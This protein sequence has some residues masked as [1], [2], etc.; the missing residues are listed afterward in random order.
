MHHVRRMVPRVQT[1]VVGGGP[2]TSSLLAN[3]VGPHHDRKLSD[4]DF[5]VVRLHPGDSMW[6]K[7]PGEFAMGQSSNMLV[8]TRYQPNHPYQRYMKVAQFNDYIEQRDRDNLV[9]M[10]ATEVS[11]R[12]LKIKKSGD[13][14]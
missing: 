8:T 10:D 14:D 1:L 7:F 5:N 9:A 4:C 12:V 2:A 13:N 11:A 6:K 3:V